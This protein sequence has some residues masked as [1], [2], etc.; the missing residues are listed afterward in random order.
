MPGAA[1]LLNSVWLWARRCCALVN[2]IS[3]GRRFERASRLADRFWPDPAHQ[4]F[5]RGHCDLAR[6]I[7]KSLFEHGRVDETN[8]PGKAANRHEA[9]TNASL[10]EAFDEELAFGER[11]QKD[12][13]QFEAAKISA[14]LVLDDD[15]FLTSSMPA[16]RDRVAGWRGRTGFPGSLPGKCASTRPNADTPWASSGQAWRACWLRYC[17]NS[18]RYGRVPSPRRSIA[19]RKISSVRRDHRRVVVRRVQAKRANPRTT[20]ASSWMLTEALQNRRLKRTGAAIRV[21]PA[22]TSSE[23]APLA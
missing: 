20:G 14:G 11:F 6:A 13:Q 19:I 3:P 5:L 1:Q 18:N 17:F 7:E 12:Y 15:H 16:R 8:T 2:D 9:I 10:R 4:R 21:Y 23:T 22:S